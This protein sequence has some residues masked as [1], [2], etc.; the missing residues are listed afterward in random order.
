MAT[1]LRFIFLITSACVLCAML[2]AADP[3]PRM[4][5]FQRIICLECFFCWFAE[6]AASMGAR[7]RLRRGVESWVEFAN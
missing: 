3:P 2:R 1:G 4:A 7:G 5:R 6:C